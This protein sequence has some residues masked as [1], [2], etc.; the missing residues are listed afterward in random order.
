LIILKKFV[1]KA[2]LQKSFLKEKLFRGYF[3]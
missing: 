1:R 2:G 3:V